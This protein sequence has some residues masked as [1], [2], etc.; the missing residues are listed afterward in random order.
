MWF[1]YER[2]RKSPSPNKSTER[3][4]PEK[5]ERPVIKGMKHKQPDKVV[6]PEFL[7]DAQL[8]G[9][10]KS[11]S[12][13]KRVVVN[14][15]NGESVTVCCDSWEVYNSKSNTVVFFVGVDKEIDVNYDN[16]T[17]IVEV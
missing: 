17:Y 4:V 12:D 10:S 2:S 5:G 3:P 13:K 8:T 6:E 7:L 1:S 9:F 16:V 14:F 11:P 15:V